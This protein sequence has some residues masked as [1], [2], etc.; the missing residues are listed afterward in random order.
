M[1]HQRMKKF[2]RVSSREGQLTIKKRSISN[3]VWL[4]S[5]STYHYEVKNRLRCESLASFL[6]ICTIKLGK[7]G[8]PYI[9]PI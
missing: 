5:F 6:F 3:H 2:I 9:S 4:H 1:G 7:E 8:E